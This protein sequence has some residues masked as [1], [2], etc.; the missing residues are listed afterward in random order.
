M[1]LI[2]QDGSSTSLRFAWTV[3]PTDQA[4]CS[5]FRITVVPRDRTEHPRTFNVDKNTNQYYVDGL[6]PNTV[7]SVTVEAST[8]SVF[9]RVNFF[10]IL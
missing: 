4:R 2:K 7:Y 1:S 9:H 10:I 6:K 8:N 5:G 3:N